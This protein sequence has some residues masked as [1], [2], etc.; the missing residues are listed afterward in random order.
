MGQEVVTSGTGASKDLLSACIRFGCYRT[1]EIEEADVSSSGQKEY[2]LVFFVHGSIRPRSRGGAFHLG[3]S[4][5]GRRS[6]DW[7]MAARTKR[8]V[9]ETVSR[10]SDVETGKRTCRCSDVRDPCGELGGFRRGKHRAALF[11]NQ[12]K[13]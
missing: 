8:S 13:M 7:K 11:H 9:D 5:L 12:T 6:L 1:T 10:S 3:H 4:V 2:N